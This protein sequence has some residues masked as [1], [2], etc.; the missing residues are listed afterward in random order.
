MRL[1]YMGLAA[2]VLAGAI[3]AATPVP[4]R[5]A[6]VVDV[7]SW[8]VLWIRRGPST[9]FGKVGSIPSNG[10]GVRVNWSDCHGNWCHVRYRGVQ[11]WTHTRYLR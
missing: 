3:S 6:C 11:G 2:L 7:A 9:R 5:A 4:A 10:C 1:I 8:D